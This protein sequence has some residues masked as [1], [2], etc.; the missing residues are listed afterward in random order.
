MP[1]PAAA[2]EPDA[3]AAQPEAAAGEEDTGYETVIVS[4][5][6]PA[7]RSKRS[8]KPDE[9]EAEAAEADGEASESE[10]DA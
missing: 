9:P 4:A 1:E 2:E 8:T 6:K 5:V 7:A 10:D 3:R